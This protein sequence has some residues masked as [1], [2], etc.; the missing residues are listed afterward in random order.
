MHVYRLYTIYDTCMHT[1]CTR[2][3]AVLKNYD[4]SIGFVALA[5][6]PGISSPRACSEKC[7]QDPKCLF[8]VRYKGDFTD[9]RLSSVAPKE[10]YQNQTVDVG[11]RC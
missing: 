2:Y 3:G 7:Q 4:V 9:C 6:I 8:W 1:D 5:T 11:A 10:I